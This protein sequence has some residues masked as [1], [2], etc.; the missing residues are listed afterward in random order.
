MALG[1]LLADNGG[2]FLAAYAI[3]IASLGGYVIALQ[4]RLNRAL[5]RQPER[6]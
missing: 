3:V 2:Y 5:N 6:E 1:E 4:R